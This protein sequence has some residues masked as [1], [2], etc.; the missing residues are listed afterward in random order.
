MLKVAVVELRV[1]S[2]LGDVDLLGSGQNVGLVH[3]ANGDTVDL[4][5]A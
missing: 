3:A 5:G 4:E 1:N 2:N